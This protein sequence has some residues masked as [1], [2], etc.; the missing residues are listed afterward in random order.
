MN[1][2]FNRRIRPVVMKLYCGTK[3]TNKRRADICG[4][5]ARARDP[6]TVYDFVARFFSALSQRRRTR[7]LTKEA[8]LT[9]TAQLSAH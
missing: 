9:S 1:P 5:G 6:E 7:V 2:A 8:V 4:N 3:P